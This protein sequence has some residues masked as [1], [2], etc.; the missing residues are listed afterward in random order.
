MAERKTYEHHF[1]QVQDDVQLHYVDVGPRDATPLVLVHGWPDIW[2]GWRHQIGALSKKYRVIAPDLRGFGRSSCP[3][4]RSGYGSKQITSDL[5]HLLDALNLP[6]AVFI[7][8]DWGGAI[9][10]RMCLYHPDRVMAVCGVVTPYM[11]PR[12]DLLDLDGYIALVPQFS[13]MKLLADSTNTAKILESSPRRLFSAIYR[14]HRELDKT[15]FLA[16]IFRGVPD[17]DDP[18]YSTPSSLLTEEELDYY[19]AEY[20]ASG[21]EACCNYYGVRPVDFESER[22]L[23]RVIQNPALYIGAADDHILKPALAAHMPMLMPKLEMK[24]VDDAGHWI[25]WEKREEVTALLLEWLPKVTTEA[26]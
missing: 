9:V 10:Y 2:F 7:G 14:H 18:S 11:P 13:Y 5:A 20:T 23:P 6:R 24:I 17:S 12:D 19:V 16:D 26:P 3:K 8:H 4:E 1:V 21:F 15:Q 25:L 22:H